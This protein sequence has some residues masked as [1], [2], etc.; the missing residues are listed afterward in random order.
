MQGDGTCLHTVSNWQAGACSQTANELLGT[1]VVCSERC[2]RVT[3]AITPILCPA[4][5][6]HDIPS[7]SRHHHG[8]R[9][10]CKQAGAFCTSLRA[11]PP[12]GTQNITQAGHKRQCSRH[13]RTR[14]H[15]AGASKPAWA[16]IGVKATLSGAVLITDVQQCV[17][18][19]S[20]GHSRSQHLLH[21]TATLLCVFAIHST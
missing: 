18:P 9:A 17:V 20:A 1:D 2:N 13:T 19:M 7:A 11:C 14:N 21:L 16:Y 3:S 5:A 8:G 6:Q 4:Q 12:L 10:G 15:P